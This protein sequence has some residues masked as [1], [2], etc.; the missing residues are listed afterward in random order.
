MTQV[1]VVGSANADLVV[2]VERRPNSGE[3]LMG[4]ELQTLPGGKG[5]NQA[6]AAGH[7]GGRVSFIGCVGNDGHGQLVRS[8]LERAHVHTEFLL[9]TETPTGTAI[10]FL[11]PDGENSI[12]VSPGA[13]HALTLALA[14]T[15]EEVW[16][17]A[18]VVALSLEIPLET[19]WRVTQDALAHNTRV[20]LNA[21]PA[22]PLPPEVLRACDPLVVN[23]HEALEVLGA[24]PNDP[25]ATHYESLARRIIVA[26]A[27]STIVTL[28]KAGAVI[29]TKHEVTRM[30]AFVVEAVDTTGA[31]D[32]FVGALAAELA[33][34]EDLHTAVTFAQAMS[35]LSVQS[36]GAQTSYVDEATV[37]TFIAER[38][39]IPEP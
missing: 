22:A 6:A 4:G 36:I 26:G 15:V 14:N 21:A 7:A 37:R 39:E 20:L 25:D 38:S 2:S 33:R 31:G 11:T 12:V 19:V 30:P 16:R 5:A 23:E 18:S 27:R 3:T 13:N 29:A 34:G 8:S 28:G 1:V 17:E 9:T 35:A 24:A 32:A 10:I